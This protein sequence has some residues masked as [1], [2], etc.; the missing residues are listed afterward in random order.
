MSIWGTFFALDGDSAPFESEGYGTG[1]RRLPDGYVWLSES[2]DFEV[3]RLN[4]AEDETRE[5]VEV[6]LDVSQAI[7]LRDALS[8]WLGK[9]GREAPDA[10]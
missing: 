1:D 7:A 2:G 5:D 10:P 3:L 8:K 9:Y 4:A 6:G